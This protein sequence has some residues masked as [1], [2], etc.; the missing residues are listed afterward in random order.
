MYDSLTTPE[1]NELQG[2]LF[3]AVEEAYWVINAE[4]G[5]RAWLERYHPMHQE[6]GNLFIEAGEELLGRLGQLVKAA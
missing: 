1:L 2:M 4:E 6:L 5:N 3:G